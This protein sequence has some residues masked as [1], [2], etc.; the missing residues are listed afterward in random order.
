[1]K[2]SVDG[3]LDEPPAFSDKSDR[4]R[5]DGAT[6][7]QVMDILRARIS[8]HDL[9]PNQ[10]IQE[11]LISSEFEISRARVREV[12]G[13]LEQRGLVERIPNRGAVVAQLKAKEIFEI[14]DV[15]EVLEGL[16]VRLA[17]QNAP[18]GTWDDI[19]ET[20]GPSMI[21]KIKGGEI[22]IYL[23][24]LDE[25][26]DRTLL[27]A[28]SAH[29]SHFLD[30]VLDKARVIAQRVT[31]LPGRAEEGCVMHHTLL[32]HMVARETEEAERYKREIIRTA[33]ACL[34]R[35]QSL[36]F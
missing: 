2:F 8:R 26:R 11:V 7:E 34:E 15:R 5:R 25:L 27:W 23:D 31:L 35:Y 17:T 28:D 16:A 21:E 4:K 36:V 13:M 3:V 1:M 19:I 9:K 33:R 30:L 32:T 29:I 14:F 6:A 12:L 18:D 10:R 24:A 22:E 20:F